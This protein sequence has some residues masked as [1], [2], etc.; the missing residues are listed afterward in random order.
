MT[1]CRV[2]PV[3][4]DEI[5]AFERYL[6]AKGADI[7]QTPAWASVKAAFGWR[8]HHLW[9]EAGGMVRGAVTI[10]EKRIFWRWSVLYAP[11]G[12]VM[13]AVPDGW[14]ALAAFVRRWPTSRPLLL[15]T[16]PDRLAAGGE[17]MRR[18]L[19]AAGFVEAPP[20]GPF[21]GIQPR[22]VYLVDL[23][24]QP[25]FEGLPGKT[26]YNIRLARRKGLTVRLGTREDVPA[27]HRLVVETARRDGFTPRNLP[28]FLRMYDCLNERRL[29]ELLIAE[30]YG[31]WVAANWV[32]HFG[33]RS[34]YFYGAS[35]TRL[36]HTMGAYLV[37]WEA[38]RRAHRLGSR[39]YD[40]R[41]AP[42]SDTPRG[43]AQGLATFKGRFGEAVD[44]I[45]EHDL[46]LSPVLYWGWRA[47]IGLGR[48]AGPSLIRPR[49]ATAR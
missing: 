46:P 33:G 34:I 3:R 32:V 1:G 22:R 27:F 5:E 25:L 20:F 40:L 10:L 43:F 31:E 23:D 16:D 8:V 44:L 26:R 18:S 11:R 7:L 2:R 49:P 41:G 47:L 15:R 48:L 4:D 38:M 24:R 28:Y 42:V 45:G 36:Q 35:S 12:P 13:D 30:K 29:A 6:E 19:E 17:D 37:Q 9:V 14:R 21:A 39:L